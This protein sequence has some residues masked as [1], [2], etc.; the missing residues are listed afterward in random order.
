MNTAHLK[1]KWLL[2]TEVTA[3]QLL[4]TKRSLLN[5]KMSHRFC[6]SISKLLETEVPYFQAETGSQLGCLFIEGQA[7]VL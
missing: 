1:L 6:S 3:T 2:V 4:A 5:L 7:F